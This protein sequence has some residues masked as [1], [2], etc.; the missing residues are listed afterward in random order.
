MSRAPIRDIS[1]KD[2]ASYAV[3]VIRV[4]P[5][6]DLPEHG[7]TWL[8]QGMDAILS[9][10]D[11][12]LALG[13]KKAHGRRAE[14][15]VRKA[16]RD[17]RIRTL[18]ACIDPENRDPT[19][20]SERAAEVIKGS[21]STPDGMEDSVESIRQAGVVGARQILRIISAE[22]PARDESATLNNLLCLWTNGR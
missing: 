21:L 1:D 9:G 10:N 12:R 19:A 3:A 22:K 18:A 5:G 11:V 2:I 14:S 17:E 7:R 8:R 4:I 6:M 20:T 13:L 16:Q 15:G